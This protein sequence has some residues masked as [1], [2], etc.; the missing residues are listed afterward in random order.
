MGRGDFSRPDL[1]RLKP[2]LP[3]TWLFGH[4][5]IVI[6]LESGILI[7][8]MSTPLSLYRSPSLS[9]FGA[10]GGIP[11]IVNGKAELGETSGKA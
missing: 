4:W 5:I 10:C 2:P 3:Q 7:F 11:I 6:C 1:G 8:W 9:T